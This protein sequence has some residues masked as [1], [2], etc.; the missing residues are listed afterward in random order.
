MEMSALMVA[1]REGHLEIMKLIV[2]A[3][4]D[5]EAR[6]NDGRTGFILA[7]AEGRLGIV[8]PFVDAG[9]S[10]E[11]RVGMSHREVADLSAR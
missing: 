8:K 3:G 9:A 2:D 7:A 5:I 4:A 6:N 1:A 11:A 10:I